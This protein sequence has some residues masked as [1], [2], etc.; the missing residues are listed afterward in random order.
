MSRK[1]KRVS[2]FGPLEECEVRIASGGPKVSLPSAKLCD[3]SRLVY[4]MLQNVC[5]ERHDREKNDEPV[6]EKR[7]IPCGIIMKNARKLAAVK[8]IVTGAPDE[9]EQLP[10]S[11]I[12]GYFSGSPAKHTSA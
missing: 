11:A 10:E 5:V 4:E 12:R 8:E 1:G 2:G 7:S 6:L 3:G 9:D